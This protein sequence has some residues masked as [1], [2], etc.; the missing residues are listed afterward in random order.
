MTSN[1]SYRDA[2]PQKY[3]RYEIANGKNKQFDPVFADIMLQ[4]IDNDKNYTMRELNYDVVDTIDD[5]DFT[6]SVLMNACPEAALSLGLSEHTAEGKHLSFSILVD[7]GQRMPGGFFVYK[8]RG[9]EELLYINDIVLKIFGCQT[10]D[11]FKILTGFTFPGMVHEKDIERIELSI[12]EQ[13]EK[14][15]NN[16]DY[17]EY[18]IRRKD[19]QI[20]WVDDYGRL[21]STLEY[22]DV[23]YVLIRDITEQHNTR[24]TLTDVDHL[25]KVYNRR[26]FDRE[27]Q[28]SVRHIM[29]LGGS[30]S[31]IMIDI[32]KFKNFNDLY[33][34]LVGDK[35]LTQVAQAMRTTL[36]RKNDLLFRYG[37]EEF[38]VLLPDAPLEDGFL[39][40]D[41]LRLAV[42]ALELPHEQ[43]PCGIITISA[44]VASLTGEEAH[45]LSDP[46]SE[47]IRLADRALYEAKGAGRDTVRIRRVE[48]C[49]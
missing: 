1:R 20:R 46:A 38:V 22:G 30:L 2:L 35:C 48:N 39:V 7:F 36:K 11:E 29:H 28:R 41:K 19:G 23:F 42:R 37:G 43:G 47:L 25:T 5:I 12:I 33:G 10:L 14:D 34:H 45:C 16:L 21:V 32:D 4:M 15:D 49:D 17:V 6:T 13:V 44:G 8:A 27:L 26:H 18:R 40:A 24:E 3:V 31:L 9:N